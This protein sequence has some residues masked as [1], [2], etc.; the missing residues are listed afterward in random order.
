MKKILLFSC[1]LM[2][3]LGLTAQNYNE[4]PGCGF[5]HDSPPKEIIPRS[6]NCYFY[7]HDFL[8]QHND[9][10]VPQGI[11]RKLKIR[12]NVVLVQ[13]QNGEYNFRTD[14]P[15]H[16]QFL[17]GIFSDMN[18][19]LEDLL[20]ESCNCSS[21]DGPVH[22]S[23]AHVEFIPN[24]I[25]LRD[26]VLWDHMIDPQPW[27]LNSFDKDYLNQINSLV[28][29]HADY[30]PG[31]NV[32]ITNEGPALEEF[33]STG[34]SLGALI[35]F[36]DIYSGQWYSS[37]AV[38]NNLDHPAMWH[39]PDL[40][41]RYLDVVTH[42][43]NAPLATGY[44]A[45]AAGGFLHEYFHMF[46]TNIGHQGGCSENVMNPNGGPTRRRSLTGCQVRSMYQA[47]MGWHVRKYVVCEDVLDFDLTID[48]DEVWKNN[49]RIYGDII[50]EEGASLT[51]TCE[52]HMQPSTNI[53]VKRGGKLIVDKGLLTGC[54][55]YWNG[56]NV[57]GY[58]SGP[59]SAAGRV[60]LINEAV[61]EDANTAISMNN[62]HLG[63]PARGEHYG[64]VVYAEKATIRNGYRALEFMKY[65]VGI[66]K[67]ESEFIDCKFEDLKEAV[68]IWSDNGVNFKQCTFKNIERR[69]ILAYDS[70]VFVS[71]ACRFE[72]MPTGVHLL[73]TYPN[74][75]SS[76]I[77]KE[78]TGVNEFY[79]R[80]NGVY[81][82]AN[83]NIAPLVIANNLFTGGKYGIQL[84]GKSFYTVEFNTFEG[85][86][87]SV[88]SVACGNDYN[89]LVN[90]EIN[91]SGLG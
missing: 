25:E 61:I 6:D 31:I 28:E 3:F 32:I 58:S 33:L 91:G 75:F 76:H 14:N 88:E 68:T 56:I 70:E 63:W 40:Y 69:G 43:P 9:D 64:G 18:N 17:N 73:T 67:D 82:Y 52:L 24:F 78:N 84:T 11:S 21:A 86:Y 12:T 80:E 26:A 55:E 74:V 39:A 30:I 10:M 42:Q 59:Q 23:N 79:C 89:L 34:K 19:R 27:K 38:V 81:S 1:L 36:Q 5:A 62:T 16:M 85:Q 53:I 49:M 44:Q 71:D 54:G 90:N 7:F 57:E 4:Y 60:E 22:Y 8:A 45:F 13:N 15:D 41:L 46:F 2:L 20:P 29:Q 47:L 35:N 37:T 77:G 87:T 66:L 65:G 72:E 50:I 48:T 83:G 51:V